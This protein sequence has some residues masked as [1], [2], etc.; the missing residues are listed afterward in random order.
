MNVIG[1]AAAALS[2]AIVGF[3]VGQLSWTALGGT[4]LVFVIL[5]GVLAISEVYPITK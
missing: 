5:V 4:A 1:L 3:G 2:G